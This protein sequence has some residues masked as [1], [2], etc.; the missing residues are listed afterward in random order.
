MC[1]LVLLYQTIPEFPLII[2]ANRDEDPDRGGDPPGL[3]P[4]GIVGPRDPRSGGTWIGVNARRVVSAVTNRQGPPAIGPQIKSR[5]TL[6]LEALKEQSAFLAHRRAERIP[7]FLFSPFHWIYADREHA[8]AMEH[9]G[10]SDFTVRLRPGLHI[11]SNVHDLNQANSG[12]VADFLR[13]DSDKPDV[14]NLWTKLS[15]LLGCHRPLLSESHEICKH[16][17]IPRTL[18]ASIIAIHRSDEK[19]NRWLYHEGTPCANRW[20]DMSDLLV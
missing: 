14:D 3:W 11:L 12:N 18:S 4:D 1:L 17:G 19:K 15:D 5:G 6:P 8:Y 20:K 16:K 2:A 9:G 13:F 10:P 7:T